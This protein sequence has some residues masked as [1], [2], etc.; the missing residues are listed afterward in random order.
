VVDD[1]VALVDCA[2][3]KPPTDINASMHAVTRAR[4]W[5]IRVAILF[6]F[7]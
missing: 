2:A 3:A 6:S 5:Q 1:P 7:H 4:F